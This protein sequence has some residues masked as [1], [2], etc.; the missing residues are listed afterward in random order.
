M[1]RADLHVHTS[2]SRDGLSSVAEVLR[3]AESR[4]LDVIAITDHD[5]IEGALEA[6]RLTSRVEVIVGE[7]ISTRSGHLI[8]LFLTEHI[9][10]GLSL[11]ESIRRV[12]AQGGLAIIPHPLWRLHVGVDLPKRGEVGFGGGVSGRSIK[13]I[14]HKDVSVRPDAVETFNASPLNG[15]IPHREV[16]ERNR[17]LWHLPEVGGSDAHHASHVGSAL[18]L[19]SG[20]TAGELR[21]SILS[22][23]TGGVGSWMGSSAALTFV[24]GNIKKRAFLARDRLM[25]GRLF[26]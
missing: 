5:T 26:R 15:R 8:G 6:A 22:G 14:L 20:S 18:T 23:D 4:G 17:H 16:A 24:G 1:G 11:E 25:L 2:Y 19:F 3:A 13:R 21:R 12:H 9:S 10:P 7:E